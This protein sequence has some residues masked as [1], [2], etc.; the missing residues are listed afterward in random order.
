HRHLHARR[1]LLHRARAARR[2]LQLL[3]HP[4]DRIAVLGAELER[5]LGLRPGARIRLPRLRD[6]DDAGLPRHAA[7]H[8]ALRGAS[9][10]QGFASHGRIPTWATRIYLGVFFSYLLFPLFYMVLLAFNDSRIPTH[11]NF[12]FTLKWFGAAWED[13]RMWDGLRV[14]VLI[15]CL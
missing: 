1:R 5:R 12:H 7:R 9:M 14:S 3:V 2:A 15:A 13:Q 10:A 6:R 11:K 8:H 4:G